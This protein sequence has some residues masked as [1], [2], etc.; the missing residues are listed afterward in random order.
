MTNAVQHGGALDRAIAR[1]GGDR[2][3]WL[4]LSTGINPV[5][6]PLSDIPAELWRRLPDEALQADCLEAARLYFDV[7]DGAVIV[8]A[9]GSQA[10]IQHLDALF[11]LGDTLIVG[12]TYGEYANRPAPGGHAMREVGA[13]PADFSEA[14]NV[15]ACH[16]NNPD[17]RLLDKERVADLLRQGQP[18][19][20]TLIVDEAFADTVPQDSMTDM[21]G[22][23]GLVVMRSFGKFFGLAGLRLGFAIGCADDMRAL[24][25]RLGPWAVSGPALWIGAQ[26][27]RDAAWIAETR[28]RLKHD[29][30]RLS[31]LLQDAGL[32]LVGGTDLFVLARHDRAVAIAE[33][34]ARRHILVRA[35]D[36]DASWLRFGLPADDTNFARLAGALAEITESLKELAAPA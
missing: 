18:S 3:D 35:F 21:A 22:A 5:P 20:G 1:F 15:I 6:Y 29:A 32:V 34:L 27:M 31:A 4:D 14:R 36:Y 17:G 11:Q 30:A 2:S 33:G 28:A 19:G 8:A 24:A 23:P 13:V 25:S 7:P 16:P 9:P 10:V 26:A 12:P